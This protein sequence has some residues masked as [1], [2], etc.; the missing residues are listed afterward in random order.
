MGR[1][2]YLSLSETRE[3]QLCFKHLKCGCQ[4]TSPQNILVYSS[5]NKIR[6]PKA[7]HKYKWKVFKKW[8]YKTF[9]PHVRN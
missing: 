9:P 1:L 2:K 4:C 8:I 5:R 3:K 7:G 6:P